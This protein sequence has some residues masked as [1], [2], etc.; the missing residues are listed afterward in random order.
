[1]DGGYLP[2]T[3]A[4]SFVTRHPGNDRVICDVEIAGAAEIDSAVTAARNAF[5]SWSQTS[6]AE[7]GAILRR[8][9]S[10]LRERN[11]E[12]AELETLD[13]GKPL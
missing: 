9:A 4:Q 1:V 7:R 10:I 3:S 12:L 6:A 11:A 5:D 13:T 8:A 2:S